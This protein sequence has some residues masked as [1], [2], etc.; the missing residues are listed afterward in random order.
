MIISYK[1]E[2]CKKEFKD[3]DWKHR[4]VCSYRCSG[5]RGNSG[6]IKKGDKLSETTKKK[7]GKASKGNKYRLGHKHSEETKRKMRESS[8][9][10][11]NYID[12]GYKGK[13]PTD[14]C[15]MCGQ[16]KKRILIHHKDKNHKN[17][18]ISNLMAVCDKCHVGIHQPDRKRTDI[19]WS[20]KESVKRYKREHHQKLKNDP[21]YRK[22]RNEYMKK[23]KKK[24]RG[25]KL[26]FTQNIF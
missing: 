6:Q 7:I 23:Y 26:L 3:H 8:K 25:D 18:D 24:K 15:S 22:K 1:C 9:R 14:K 20:D 5:L 16:S 17:N 19:D 11:P 21:E 4:K 12:G 10:P 2:Y 13:I